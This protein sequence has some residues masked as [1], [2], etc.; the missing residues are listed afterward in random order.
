M[1]EK[2]IALTIAGMAVVTYLPR[3]LPLLTLTRQ[4]HSESRGA[5]LF[6]AWLR[7]V[8]AAVLAAML[9]PSLFVAEG[10]LHVSVDNLY[11]WAAI[12]TWLV[13]WRTRSLW[14]AVVT[15]VVVLAVARLVVG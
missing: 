10:R 4:S 9:M 13:A 5:R 3:L 14:A 2:T 11:L 15:G 12:P 7:H 6:E 8:P 1:D